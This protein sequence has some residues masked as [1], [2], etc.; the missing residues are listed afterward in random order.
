MNKSK[1]PNSFFVIGILLIASVMGLEAQQSEFVSKDNVVKITQ[2]EQYSVTEDPSD[3]GAPASY[4]IV[5][6]GTQI[7]GRV[8][9]AKAPVGGWTGKPKNAGICRE[10]VTMRG[11]NE[12][13]PKPTIQYADVK[14]GKLFPKFKFDFA[15]S[16]TYD[17]RFDGGTHVGMTV[18]LKKNN[19]YWDVTVHSNAGEKVA[20]MTE[21]FGLVAKNL[22][23]D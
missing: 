3:D 9:F 19:N 10:L 22:Q 5:F 13:K 7:E 11:Y 2:S 21:L 23:I 17:R 20:K 16:V 12:V 4:S 15:C 18:I 8:G 14:N 1:N 6:P